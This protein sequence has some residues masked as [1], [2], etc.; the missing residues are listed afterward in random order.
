MRQDE[1]DVGARGS[2]QED[3]GVGDEKKKQAVDVT[4][5]QAGDKN[6]KKKKGLFGRVGLGNK[7]KAGKTGW[8]QP[9]RDVSVTPRPEI[10]DGS[11]D[12]LV[13]NFDPSNPNK[14]I[15][16]GWLSK[17]TNRNSSLLK[18]N[19]KRWCVLKHGTLQYFHKKPDSASDIPGGSIDLST[20]C[21]YAC[22]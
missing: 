5:E 17:E 4:E 14:I 9:E 20:V 10:E 6:A 7:N 19:R 2:A 3:A 11:D 16:E 13:T 22:F 8:T 15:L 1:E 21:S 12:W 18:S